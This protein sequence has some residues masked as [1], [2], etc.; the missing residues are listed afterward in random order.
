MYFKESLKKGVVVIFVMK[1]AYATWLLANK[2]N[3]QNNG[4]AIITSHMSMFITKTSSN[5]LYWVAYTSGT[6]DAEATTSKQ[7]R[8]RRAFIIYLKIYY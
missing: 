2:E 6:E 1:F 3:S 7:A 5:H 8:I 4:A